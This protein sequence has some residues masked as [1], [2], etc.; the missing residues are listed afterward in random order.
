MLLLRTHLRSEKSVET[1]R[2]ARYQVRHQDM[3]IRMVPPLCLG[4]SK[5]LQETKTEILV[6]H[7]EFSSNHDIPLGEIDLPL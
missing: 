7:F 2:N 6:L 5:S 3:A 4:D 1:P